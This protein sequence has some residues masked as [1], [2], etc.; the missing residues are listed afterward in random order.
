MRN[1]DCGLRNYKDS[2]NRPPPRR[3]SRLWKIRNLK[4]LNSQPSAINRLRSS[5]TSGLARFSRRNSCRESRGRVSRRRCFRRV[6]R[7]RAARGLRLPDLGLDPHKHL[8]V[9]GVLRR[10]RDHA[11]LR[12]ELPRVLRSG[13]QLLALT[14]DYPQELVARL[15]RAAPREDALTAARASTLALF[16]ELFPGEILSPGQLVSV[17]NVGSDTPARRPS[18]CA[19]NRSS[20]AGRLFA[21]PATRIGGC[22]S[23]PAIPRTFADSVN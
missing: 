19:T 11:E 9:R 8:P 2:D 17:A 15:E 20:T 18:S 16:R 7:K 14:N 10:Q 22:R 5:P 1:A 4:T 3:R 13:R 23:V 21:G 12:A 6:P